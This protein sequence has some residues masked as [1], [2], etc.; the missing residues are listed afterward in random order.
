M[1]AREFIMKDGYSFHLD[2]T[3]STPPIKRC[4]TARRILR[5]M[6]LDFKAV[7][8]DTGNIGGNNSHEFHVLAAYGEDTIVYAS[9]GPY[10]ANL[11]KAVAAVPEPSTTTAEPL[12][13]VATP[14]Q[15]TIAAVA[16]LLNIPGLVRQNPRG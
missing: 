15:K 3:V 16:E 1:R 9:D 13:R 14:T 11:E 4:T 7:E 12:E 8:A 10:A 6:Q 5:R 2:Q